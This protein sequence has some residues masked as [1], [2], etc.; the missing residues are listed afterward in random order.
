M[1]IIYA[2]QRIIFITFSTERLEVIGYANHL[3]L[4]D[5]NDE[6][7]TKVNKEIVEVIRLSN[8][9]QEELLKP[10]LKTQV[11]SSKFRS[12]KIFSFG[13]RNSSSNIN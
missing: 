2:N 7:E 8:P 3:C 12:L 1:Y 10:L 5:E 4:F 9:Q 11:P 13:Y 6:I